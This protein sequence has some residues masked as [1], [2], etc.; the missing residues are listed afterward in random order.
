MIK[1]EIVE[2]YTL[3]VIK[4]ILTNSQGPGCMFCLNFGQNAQTLKNDKSNP[5]EGRGWSGEGKRKRKRVWSNGS[6]RRRPGEP[7]EIQTAPLHFFQL[8]SPFLESWKQDGK[9]AGVSYMIYIAGHSCWKS[10]NFYKQI[11]LANFVMD[12]LLAVFFAAAS[13]ASFLS[14]QRTRWALS[15]INESTDKDYLTCL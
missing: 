8:F 5:E 11:Y 14:S 2:W 3:C 10:C 1:E 4:Y 15:K 13:L 12:S 7:M 9:R 6:R